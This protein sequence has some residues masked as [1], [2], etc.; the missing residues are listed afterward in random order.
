MEND[1]VS[2]NRCSNKWVMGNILCRNG[3]GISSNTADT[4]IILYKEELDMHITVLSILSLLMTMFQDWETLDN[5]V[6][7]ISDCT[8]IMINKQSNERVWIYKDRIIYHQKKG[9]WYVFYKE[10]DT[11]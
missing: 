6:P 2:S 7:E 4:I 5:Y 10:T 9:L 1:Y 3:D 11:D 8:Q